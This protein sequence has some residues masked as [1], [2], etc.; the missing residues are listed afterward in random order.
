M[1]KQISSKYLVA[2]LTI[3][4]VSIALAC[5]AFSTP[6]N[7]V[8]TVPYKMNFQGRIA[9]ASGNPMPTGTYNM[10]FRIYDALTG[11]TLQWS[12][13]RANSASTGVAVTNGLFSVQLG[14]VT[15]LP[16]TIFTNQNLYFEIEMPTPATATCSTASCES[17]A[18]GPM[19]PRNKLG[20]SAY[21]FNSDTLDG[22][23]STAFAA[24]S[25]SAS[26]IQNQSASQQ[27]ASSYWISGTARADTAVVTPAIRPLA[28]G[29]TAFRIQNASGASTLFTADTSAMQIVIGSTTNGI[30][31]SSNGLTYLGTARPS[32]TITLSPE[33][34]GAT[35]T[36]DGTSNSGTLTSDFCSGSTLLNINAAACSLPSTS[37]AH[38]YYQW[39]GTAAGNQ[40][41]DVYVR[42]QMP[43]DYD[44]GS[45]ANLA[46][47][48]FG[49]TT[50]SEQV[51]VGLYTDTQA[52]ACGATTNAVTSNATWIKVTAASPLGSCT[53][54]AGDTV[55]LKVHLQ[56][57]QSNFA[58]AG[59]ISFNYKKKF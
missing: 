38:N 11:G 16:A 21:A 35:F 37:I 51:T 39:T 28:D 13:Q 50:A 20:T 5:F 18:E 45:L 8:Q 15:S 33:Y 32:N 30:T 49:T 23:D 41:Y 31:F 53:I 12:E 47:W 42:Y 9:D 2:I 52:A 14:D 19:G 3:P 34:A 43:S 6:A 27:T 59:E 56:A 36:P 22:L 54:V 29:T 58:R 46:I 7:A 10:K 55:T 17:Y 44:T 25:G 48:G 4:V 40:D 1:L 26:Y 24:A 57:A